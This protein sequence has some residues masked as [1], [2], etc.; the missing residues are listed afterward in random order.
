MRK[1]IALWLMVLGMFLTFP[2]AEADVTQWVDPMIGT[3]NYGTCNPGA[4]VPWGL[5]SVSPFNVMGSDLNRYDKDQQWFSTPYEHQN[6][7]LTGFSHVNL[8]GVG[9]PDLG[10]LLVMATTGTVDVDYHNYGTTYGNE[11]ATPGYYSVELDRYGILAE[12]TAT[13]RTSRLRFSSPLPMNLLLNLGEGLTNETGATVRKVG[14]NRWEGVKLMGTFCYNPQAV[15]PLYFVME[16]VESPEKSGYWKKQRPMQGI[17]A[18][19]DHDNGR[20]KIYDSYEG[21]LSGDDVGV[22]AQMPDSLKTVEVKI[23]VS[24]NSTENAW[25]NLQAEQ[26]EDATFDSL[27]EQAQQ[28]WEAELS[29]IEVQGG[30]NDE[31]T[32]FYTALYHS[33]IHPSKCNDTGEED[34]YTVFSLWDTYRTLHPLICLAYPERQTAMVR[35]IINFAKANGHMPR[36]EL[37]GQETLTMEG[38][39]ALIVI[40]DS[41]FRGIRDFDIEGAYE[42]MRKSATSKSVIRPDYHDYDTLGFVPIRSQNDNSVSHALEYYTADAAMSLLAKELGKEDDAR[43]FRERSLGY[44]HYYD[45]VSGFLRPK[46]ANGEFFSPFNPEAG[47]DFSNAPGFHEGTAWN[48]LFAVPHDY[49]GLAQLMGGKEKM[50]QKLDTLFA[51]GHYD[52]AN[53]PDISFPYIYAQFGERAKS[54]KLSHQLLQ[55]YYNTTPAGL[56]G[57]DDCGTMSA[58]AVW[59]MMG[60]YPQVPSKGSYIHTEP[61]FK[62]V[63]INGR[64]VREIP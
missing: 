44:K 11:T 22:W 35:S 60:L 64:D 59:T 33:L 36:W 41:Y 27:R 10:G 62:S 7:F 55:K 28:A 29:K 31:K 53:E 20:Y 54:A 34:N 8:S 61:V 3:S 14:P 47:A 12:A 37:M 40:A 42:L 6:K 50:L 26:P 25:R 56:P 46:R 4:I 17:E 21:P 43:F 5:M 13:E 57:N 2:K 15:F 48:Y 52:P 39:P 18:E 38:D 19:W 24:L 32:I 23:G 9:C 16:M 58:W 51:R 1:Q 49:D 30:T 63:K 45:S